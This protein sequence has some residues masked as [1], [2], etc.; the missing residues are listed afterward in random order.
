MTE[1]DEHMPRPNKG[2]VHRLR[3][4]VIAGAVIFSFLVIPLIF[5]DP[6]GWH[7]IDRFRGDYD[8]TLAAVPAFV[9][10]TRTL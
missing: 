10:S 8:A 4:A 1:I 3:M 2:E 7:L 5:W 9:S 6:F